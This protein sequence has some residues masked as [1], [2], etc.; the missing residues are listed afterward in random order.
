MIVFPRLLVDLLDQRRAGHLAQDFAQHVLDIERDE[1]AQ[2]VL[3]ACLELIAAAH[4]VIDLGET[5]PQ[6]FQT[7]ERH[8]VGTGRLE[9]KRQG[10]ARHPAAWYAK[11]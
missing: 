10:A 4:E 9:G 8:L 1:I 6:Y 7:S 3:A 2:P 11:R 5:H